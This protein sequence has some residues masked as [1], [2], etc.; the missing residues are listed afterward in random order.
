MMPWKTLVSIATYNERENIERLVAAVRES[1]S[2][3]HVLV[4]DD[5]SPDGTGQWCEHFD[6]EQD[7]FHYIQRGSKQGLGSA[8]IC[9]MQYAVEQGYDSV[10]YTHLTLPTILLV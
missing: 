6:D 7:W 5:G 1:V 3:I 8:T 10:S 2:D 4:I 9:G